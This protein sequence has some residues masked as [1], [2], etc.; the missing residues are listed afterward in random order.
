MR[1]RPINLRGVGIARNECVPPEGGW[2][3]RAQPAFPVQQFALELPIE[4]QFALVYLRKSGAESAA[5]LICRRL[6]QEGTRFPVGGPWRDLRREGYVTYEPVGRN[7][8]SPGHRLT[9]RGMHASSD[10]IK[11]LCFKYSIHVFT[12]SGGRG[13]GGGTWTRCSCGTWS[14]GPHNNDR[15]GEGRIRTAETAHWRDVTTGAWPV[16]TAAEQLN[17]FSPLK[18]DF[19]SGNALL[20]PPADAVRPEAP[21][22]VAIV[23]AAAVPGENAEVGHG[24]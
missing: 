13:S 24:S 10:I 11:H 12:H 17:R 15:Y 8:V 22:T 14:S 18:F 23:L 6:E 5:S 16:R 2:P 9:P 4:Q 21:G 19:Q 3:T 7:R 20:A 1:S